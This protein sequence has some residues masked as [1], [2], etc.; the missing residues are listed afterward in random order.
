MANPLAASF[1]STNAN[2]N[3]ALPG[4]TVTFAFTDT[5]LNATEVLVSVL[6]NVDFL[7]SS[8]AKVTDRPIGGFRGK[9]V[10]GKMQ[11]DQILGAPLPAIPDPVNIRVASSAATGS[12]SLFAHMPEPEQIF[13]HTL[14]LKVE[15]KVAGKKEIFEGQSL[16]QVEYPMAMIVGK[17]P[18]TQDP[19][20]A[21]VE[22]WANQWK[23]FKPLFRHVERTTVSR[24]QNRNIKPDD[25]DDLVRAFKVCASKAT[26]G[27]I[28]LA[29]GHGDGGDTQAIAWCN[30]V[31]ENFKPPEATAAEPN[32]PFLYRLDIDENALGDGANPGSIPGGQNV[33]KLNALD[34]IADALAD[35]PVRRILLHTCRAGTSEIFMQRMADRLRVPVVAHRAKIEYTGA[36]NSNQILA[37]YE[38]LTPVSPRD[39]RHW[40]VSRLSKVFRP[41]ATPPKRFPVP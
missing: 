24:I 12:P 19:S 1:F 30:L 6:E 25:Y 22:S 21:V 34:R 36:A 39:L 8:N 11:V 7:N 23:A 32:P 14:R 16:L 17:P 41:F 13:N 20:I 33:V 38:G 2:S 28:A 4:D 26:A 31:P 35:S 37:S 27:V 3:L 5:Q 29:T 15:G 9:V 10:N 40:P 18:G